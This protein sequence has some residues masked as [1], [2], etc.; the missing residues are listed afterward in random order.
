MQTKVNGKWKVIGHPASVSLNSVR[1][2]V[3]QSG[4]DRVL[5]EKKKYVHAFVEGELEFSNHGV[6]SNGQAISYNPYKMDS[7]YLVSTEQP[8]KT[9]AWAEIH[10]DDK[11]SIMKVIL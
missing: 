2:L 6:L 1:F 9:A 8:I 3:Y 11:R 10:S 7:F 5:R 4:R